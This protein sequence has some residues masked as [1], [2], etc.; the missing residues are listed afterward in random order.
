MKAGGGVVKVEEVRVGV[1]LSDC[2]G[3]ISKI[4]DFKD[5]TSYAEKLPGVVYVR[6]NNEFCAEKGLKIIKDAIKAEK[7]NRIVVSADEPVTCTVRVGEAIQEAGL[8]PYLSEV[9]YLREHCALPHRSEPEK[10]TQKARAMLRAAVE[11]VKLAEPLETLKY[12]VRKSALVIGGGIAGIQAAINLTDMGFPVH[13]VEREPFLGGLA[14]RAGRFFPTDDCALCIGSSSCSLHGVTQTSRKCLYRSGFSEIPNLKILTNANV[15]ALEGE[16]GNYKVTVDKKI[17]AP[18]FAHGYPDIR[19]ADEQFYKFAEQKQEAPPTD[20]A[21]SERLTLDVGA[22]VVATGFEEF[23]AS[24]IKEYRYGVYPDVVTQLEL[25]R[26]LDA[27][28]P[29]GGALTRPSDKSR[30]RRVVMIQCAGS[31]DAR[32]NAYCSSIC[33][34][35]ALKHSLIIKDKYPDVDV[36]ICYI[37][38]RS[39]GRGHEDYYERAREAGVK[40]VKGRPTEIVEDP[41][42]KKLIVD[43]EDELAGKLAELEADLVV[44]STAF[45]PSKGTNELAQT[46][47]LELDG[48]GFFKEYNAKVRPT[49]T[50]LRGIYLCGGATFPKDSPTTAL[51]AAS[52][53]VKAAK[54][55]AQDFIVKDR[56]TAMVD[57][58]LCGDCE[59]CPVTCPYGAISLEETEDHNTA[60]RDLR[61]AF[62]LNVAKQKGGHFVVRIDDQ[63]CEACGICVGTCP[64]NAIDL[65]QARESQILAQVKALTSNED[66]AGPIV[67]AFCCAECGGTS[68]DS[69][70]MAAMEYPANVRVVKVPCTGILKIHHLL[71]AF[72]MGADAVMVVGCKVDGCHYEEGSTKAQRKVELAKKLLELYGIEPERLEM[73]HNIYIEGNQFAQQAKTMTQRAETLGPIQRKI[74]EG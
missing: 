57:P 23:D 46:L 19:I 62:A 48:D 6:Q 7:L 25:A 11:K 42:T 50:K 32:Y 51:H 29:T 27:F 36:Q 15:V 18:A 49:E 71:E 5:L 55:M 26:M 2:D 34:M 43:T 63:K 21:P 41:E 1:F 38:I 56:K 65:R 31:R 10:A 73:F 4:L 54:F 22:I 68:V 35:I 37:D 53:A 52:A 47:G 69:A 30:P 60:R 58:E 16:P 12:P 67:L 8:N 14:A 70:G 45:I 59:F 20:S 3:Q 40:F 24:V 72:N 9:I 74:V 66:D 64:L 44:L 61:S 13:L 17:G 39:W 33:C 28:G